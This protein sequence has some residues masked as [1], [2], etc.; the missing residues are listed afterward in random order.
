[1]SNRDLPTARLL[2]PAEAKVTFVRRKAP[3]SAPAKD[4][5]A[6][7]GGDGFVPLTA[8]PEEAEVAIIKPEDPKVAPVR[9][10]LK[11]LSGD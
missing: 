8:T 7:S 6:A 9:R 5:P 2:E 11:A 3:A 10:F 4:S 1:M